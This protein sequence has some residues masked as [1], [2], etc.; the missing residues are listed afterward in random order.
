MIYSPLLSRCLVL[1]RRHNFIIEIT[2]LHFAI[3][4]YVFAFL[5]LGHFKWSCCAVCTVTN[6][7]FPFDTRKKYLRKY[8][9]MQ[10]FPLY[11]YTFNHLVI[12]ISTCSH[13]RFFRWEFF[14]VLPAMSLLPLS[15]FFLKFK[16]ILST[17]R[18][19]IWP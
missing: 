10:F 16:F 14:N 1:S 13:S 17:S 12:L 4:N 9:Y 8:S 5:R 3:S 11:S 7:I 6:D 19:N 18:Q 15:L 2:V